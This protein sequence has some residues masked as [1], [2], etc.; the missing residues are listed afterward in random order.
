MSAAGRT[1]TRGFTSTTRARLPRATRSRAWGPCCAPR[2]LRSSPSTFRTSKATPRRSPSTPFPRVSNHVRPLPAPSRS[3]PP[4]PLAQVTVSTCRTSHLWAELADEAPSPDAADALVAPTD[5]SLWAECPDPWAFLASMATAQSSS[6]AISSPASASSH[7]SSYATSAL[8]WERAS[9][10]SCAN[11]SSA[12]GSSGNGGVVLVQAGAGGTSASGAPA[13]AR[14]SSATLIVG[15]AAR[16][17]QARGL[18]RIFILVT[19]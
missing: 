16:L 12:A 5:V 8:R 14:G 13:S 2:A 15:D 4:P 1:S 6:S 10:G 3:L 19:R 7:S 11:V 17:Q 9:R 18:Q